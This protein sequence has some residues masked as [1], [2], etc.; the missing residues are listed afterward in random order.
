MN[1]LETIKEVRKLLIQNKTKVALGKLL[2]FCEKYSHISDLHEIEDFLILQINRIAS[3]E[4]R[5]VKGIIKFEEA[6][7][8]EN[9][10]IDRT[11]KISREIERLE[12]Y[13]ADHDS[14]EDYEEIERNK[15]IGSWIADYFDYFYDNG[16]L[17]KEIWT[18]LPDYS[19]TYDYFDKGSMKYIGHSSVEKWEY[20]KGILREVGQGDYEGES[21]IEWVNEDTILLTIITSESSEING[22]RKVYK[23]LK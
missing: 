4:D 5:L 22:F 13:E 17:I 8:V 15:I 18:L 16:T 6:D 14:E 10:I 3:I 20:S 23:R 7:Y 21:F 12:I 2:N 19:V 1:Q 11:L 9:I